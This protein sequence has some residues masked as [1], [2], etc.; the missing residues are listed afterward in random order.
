[1]QK[2]KVLTIHLRVCIVLGV[3]LLGASPVFSQST[4][5]WRV[6]DQGNLT[7]NDQ[8]F[9]I[10]GGSWTGLEGREEPAEDPNNPG[11]APMEMYLGNCW[12]APSGRTYEQ[13]IT[14]FKQLGFNT[15]RLPIVP[16]TLDPGDPQGRE[17]YL[18]NDPYV[19]IENARLAMETVITLLDE[20]GLYV[21]PEIHSCSNSVGRKAGRLDTTPPYAYEC[22]EDLPEWGEDEPSCD[23][24][25]TKWL[26]DLRELAGLA[27]DLGVTNI[28]GIDIFNEPWDYTW[29][30]WR[31]LIDQAYGAINEVN[32]NILIFAQGIGSHAQLGTIVS[33]NGDPASKPN[34]GENLYEAG[35]NPPA[36]PKDRLVFSPHT[37]GPS[38]YVQKM[39]MDPD[40]P[41]CEGLEGDDAGENECRIVINPDLLESGWEE[42]FGYLKDLGYAVVIGAFG[43]NPD[44]PENVEVCVKDLW[45]WLP[46][47][48][49]DW[50]WQNAFANYLISKK[51]QDAIYWAINPE[52]RDTG[53]IY[54]HAFDPVSNTAG[55]GI[56][57]GVDE[58]KL[59]LLYSIWNGHGDPPPPTAA[60]TP[61]PVSPV[62]GDVNGDNSI[63]IIDALM[64]AQHYVGLAPAGFIAQNADVDCDGSITIVD[65]L[66]IAQYYVE[67]IHSFNC[68]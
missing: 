52:H 54:H 1:M 5:V 35:F 36:M 8:I 49:V 42:H 62:L 61:P 53:G 47:K 64:T 4:P 19:R 3:I 25:V 65:A 11:G 31:S 38:V 16:Q 60:P 32:P 18:K 12:W 33:P 37:F 7:V 9:H 63:D 45:S 43:G 2:K 59:N 50:Q 14:E 39:F 24:D 68:Q 17:P 57:Q 28:M 67:L 44:W 29:E 41:Q 20:A 48:T 6:D 40:Q 26:D 30:E 22:W 21:L 58:R 10:K 46:D 23:Y 51:M 13:D 56:W 55:W 27:A 66:L 34:W 15:I